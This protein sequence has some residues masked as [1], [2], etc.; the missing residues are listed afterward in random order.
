MINLE[1]MDKIILLL[2]NRH[3]KEGIG[4]ENCYT[5]GIL[6]PVIDVLGGDDSYIRMQSDSKMY[7]LPTAEFEIDLDIQD[8]IRAVNPDYIIACGVAAKKSVEGLEYPI[9]KMPHPAWR[10]FNKEMQLKCAE[11]V[12]QRYVGDLEDL[13]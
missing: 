12:A 4:W 8:R 3:D 10:G 7:P 5:H 13:L 2:Q 6:K 1:K 11:A 9:F